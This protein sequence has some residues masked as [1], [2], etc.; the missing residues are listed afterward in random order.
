M[1]ILVLGSAGQIGSHFVEYVRTQM[2]YDVTTFDIEVIPYRIYA[3]DL[4]P[5][6]RLSPIVTW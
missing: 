3:Y 6:S 1:N 2:T 5:W 4:S